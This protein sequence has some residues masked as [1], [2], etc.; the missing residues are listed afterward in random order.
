MNLILKIQHQHRSGVL[1]CR[2]EEEDEELKARERA[3]G[4]GF[5]FFKSCKRN[6]ENMVIR[7]LEIRVRGTWGGYFRP[8]LHEG[9]KSGAL[10]R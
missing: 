4:P 10:G 1:P 6:K 9:E 7:N 2:Q 8:R 3:F 5:C